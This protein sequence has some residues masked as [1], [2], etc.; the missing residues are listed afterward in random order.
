MR[1]LVLTSD[2]LRHRYF[3]KVISEKFDL[4]GA[5]YE[6]KG[7]YYNKCQRESSLIE[8]HFAKLLETEK[9]FF[10]KDVKDFKFK[11]IEIKNIN[12]NQINDADI[13]DWAKEL[14]PDFIF[15]FG[16]GILKDAWLHNF[17]N[18]IINLHLGLSPFYRGSA[19]LFWPF[20]NDELECIGA[21]IHIA[22]KKVDAGGILC[23]IKPDISVNDNYYTIN[24]KTI[25]KAIDIFPGV[26]Q[27][28]LDGDIIP[29]KQNNEIGKVFKKNDF[30]E[31]ILAKVLKKYKDS[32]PEDLFKNIKGSNKCICCQ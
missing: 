6:D 2:S 13:I 20:V 27:K 10:E 4:L 30:T 14:K 18:K 23:R 1:T 16:T 11:N 3:L 31:G 32:I 7:D 15:L 29:V 25:K 8:K 24:Y 9:R 12:K 17:E 28:F 5:I 26:A 22:T 19:T 21:T